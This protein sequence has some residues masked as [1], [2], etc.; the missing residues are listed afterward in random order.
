MCIFR[1]Y[2]DRFDSY[3]TTTNKPK[4]VEQ[5]DI[6]GN[7]IQSNIV[8]QVTGGTFLYKKDCAIVFQVES[9]YLVITPDL[10]VC[11]LTDL[12]YAIGVC[13]IS[14]EYILFRDYF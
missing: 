11:A 7:L 14:S 4:V 5:Y 12:P 8:S 10:K 13:C 1:F 9:K 6:N 2:T 3:V